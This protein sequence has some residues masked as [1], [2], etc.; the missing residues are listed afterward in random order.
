MWKQIK[1]FVL[2]VSIALNVAFVGVWLAHA[3]AGGRAV[4]ESGG[5]A[6]EAVWCPLHRQLNVTA[7]QWREIEPR[8][9]EFRESADAICLEIN[10]LRT[11]VIDELAGPEPDL[12][13]VVEKQEQIL[14]SQRRMQKLVIGQLLHEKQVLTETQQQQLFEML[15]SRMGCDRRGPALAPGRGHESGIG[16]IIR[17]G[18]Q[19]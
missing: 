5:G 19:D 11:G 2:T 4:G 1:P 10:G 3:A 7:E 13:A 8:L 9:R 16:Q 14:G 6:E 12:Q 18:G 15:R 17:S